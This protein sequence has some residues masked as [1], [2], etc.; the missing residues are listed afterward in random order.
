MLEHILHRISHILSSLYV[1]YIDI[2][3]IRLG[4]SWNV[5]HN[6]EAFLPSSAIDN[7]ILALF[8]LLLRHKHGLG[9]SKLQR[10]AQFQQYV[11]WR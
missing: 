7:A 2:G 3:A 5:Q 6:L 11:E 9:V 4:H 8:N 10:P 1:F